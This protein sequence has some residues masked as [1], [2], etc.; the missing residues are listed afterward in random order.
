MNGIHAW[1]AACA[2]SW[3]CLA[4]TALAEP[5]AFETPDEAVAAVIAAV[6]A[7]D[8]PALLAVFGPEAKDILFSGDEVTDRAIWREFLASYREEHRIEVTEGGVAVLHVGRAD[9]PFPPQIVASATGWRFDAEHA[10]EEILAR[11]IG[12]NELDVMDLLRAGV[13]VQQAYRAADHDGDGVLEFA[14]GILSS[15]GTRDGLYWPE[16][17]GTEESPIG[18]F[19]ARASAD[20]YNFEGTDEAPDPYM[21][22][23]F[24]I[25]Q[26]QGPNA[27]GG[28]YDYIMGGNMVAGHAYLAY[29]AEYGQ[30]GIISFMVGE[31]GVIYE[32]DL[33]PDTEALAAAIQSFDPGQGWAKA[34]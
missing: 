23:Y 20:G 1:S 7:E 34:E 29:P 17:E 14:A 8:G 10:R 12:L 4:G 5:T 24:R 11:R 33:G 2:F 3:L 28:A 9:W 32:A 6:E 19:L 13:G 27:P 21:G 16:E 30:S 22:Y 26:S 15:P 31:A 25:L 18:D